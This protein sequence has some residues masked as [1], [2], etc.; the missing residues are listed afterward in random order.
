M[1]IQVN[2]YCLLHVSLAKFTWIVFL[3]IFA[4][5]LPSSHFLAALD[6]TSFF[7]M[8]FLV[9][10]HSFYSW[11]VLDYSFCNCILYIASILLKCLLLSTFFFPY[12]WQLMDLMS[13]KIHKYYVNAG[14]ILILMQLI[15]FFNLAELWTLT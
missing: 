13:F 11:A 15:F 4:I 8:A 12:R 5:S 10:A 9:A 3:K 14:L 1:T 2:L 6:F 7:T